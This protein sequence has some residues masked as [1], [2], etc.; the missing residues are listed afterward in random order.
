[1]PAAILFAAAILKGLDP[2]LFAEQI[3]AHK[4][5]PASWS[6]S[7]AHLFIAV[8]LLLGTALVLGLKLRWTHLLF[9][10]LMLGFIVATAIAWS[11]GNTKECG[12][13]GRSVGQGP[14]KV[15][16]R[17]CGLIVISLVAL[18]LLRGV[19]TRRWCATIG[20]ILLPL[21]LVFTAFG[22]RI[23]ADGFV[24]GLHRGSELGKL[25]IEDL[26]T[27]HTEGTILLV[28]VDEDCTP[29]AEAIPQLNEIARTGKDRM[30]VAAVFAGSRKDATAWR[31][32]HLPAFPVA[33]AS[34]RA[35]R[36]YYRNLPVCFLCENG[37][38][39]HAFWREIPKVEDLAPFL[40]DQD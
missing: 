17:D 16:L 33:H 20:V 40:S 34:A 30:R 38:L 21:I 24:T 5:T 3:T 9:I 4:I 19:R 26:R 28:L 14:L 32:K 1:V 18:W 12:C 22:Q 10:G 25:P 31:M 23:P 15:I 29:C 35:L 2:S 27:P 8:E 6:Q 13:F 37:K 7:L 39:V 36:A 11:H